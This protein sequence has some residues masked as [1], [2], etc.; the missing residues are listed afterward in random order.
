[1]A[2]GVIQVLALSAAAFCACALAAACGNDA[3]GVE[4]CRQVETARCQQ[5][6]HCPNINLGTPV[7]RD[8]PATDIEACT[9]YYRDACL[10]GLETTTDPGSVVAKA[11]VDAISLGDCAVVYHPE[12]HP[13]C[14][15][16]IPPAAAVDA[17]AA[18]MA[19]AA[20]AD[21]AVAADAPAQ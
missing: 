1:M 9:R 5:A 8:S 20:A 13:S 4:T 14:A 18:A 21:T 12:T 2:R 10:H 6:P 16:L 7:H 15:W 17:A 3:V 19:D 11:C